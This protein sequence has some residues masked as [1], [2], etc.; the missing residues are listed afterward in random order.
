MGEIMNN[1]ISIN[2]RNRGINIASASRTV[3]CDFSLSIKL[4]PF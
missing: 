3:F 2:V 4:W 1:T